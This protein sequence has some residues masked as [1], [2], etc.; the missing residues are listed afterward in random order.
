MRNTLLTL[1][2]LPVLLAAGPGAK[3]Y[4]NPL[5]L[6]SYPVQ[7]SSGRDLRSMADPTVLRYKDKW[8]LYPSNGMAWVSSDLVNWTYHPVVVPDAHQDVI[9]APSVFEYKGSST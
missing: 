3:R 6:P 5:P 9:W 1:C 7:H 2:A 4:V 8:Y